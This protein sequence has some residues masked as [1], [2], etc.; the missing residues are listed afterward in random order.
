[1]SISSGGGATVVDVRQG[2]T[3]FER[4]AG[5][6]ITA[7]SLSPDDTYV[8]VKGNDASLKVWNLE[9]GDEAIGRYSAVQNVCLA[10]G[11][12]GLWVASSS[13]RNLSLWRISGSYLIKCWE[14]NAEHDWGSLQL[15]A[16]SE[17][18]LLASYQTGVKV[19]NTMTG[20]VL[21]NFEFHPEIKT[22]DPEVLR[23]G[24]GAWGRLVLERDDEKPEAILIRETESGAVVGRVRTKYKK[25][26]WSNCGQF[27]VSVD[28]T[29]I[30]DNSLNLWDPRSIENE[31]PLYRFYDKSYLGDQYWIESSMS[32]KY[33]LLYSVSGK[34]PFR[35][36]FWSLE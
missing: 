24:M 12:N 36:R 11:S 5:T 2:V 25:P 34:T 16:R 14:S 15:A 17:N 27:V 1:M 28:T 13:S 7:V 35:V 21:K 29:D 6:E 4:Y 23:S 3:L 32:G 9:R 33:F 8:A 18:E 31:K 22:R 26:R 30:V 19:W 20:Q 10:I